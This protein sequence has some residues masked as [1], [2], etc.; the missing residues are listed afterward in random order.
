MICSAILNRYTDSTLTN[1]K[2]NQEKI[3]YM[4]P[5]IQHVKLNVHSYYAVTVAQWYVYKIPSVE[6]FGSVFFSSMNSKQFC[7]ES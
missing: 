1:K 7:I 2:A 3:D 5:Q 6:Y 4:A